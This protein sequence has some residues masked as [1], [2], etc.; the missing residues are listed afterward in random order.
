M[1][2]IP[3]YLQPALSPVAQPEAIVRAGV[4]RFTLLA[5]G[6]LRL[7]YDPH[8]QFVD[9]ASQVFWYRDQPVPD[10][11]VSENGVWLTLTTEVLRLR[12]RKDTPFSADTLQITLLADGTEWHYG[13]TDDANLK[14]TTR[15]LDGLSGATPLEPGLLSRHGW[16]VVDD[17][18][19]LLFN[20]DGW[21]EPRPDR[22][23]LDLYFF[24]YPDPAGSGAD[25]Q[26]ALDYYLRI[27]GRVPMLPRW[28]L[29][30]W[31]SRY[32][33]YSQEELTN[34]MRAFLRYKIPLAVC[35]VDM[36]W[37][38]TDTGNTS[39]GWTG[40]TWNRD[41]FPDPDGFIHWL[42]EQ[43][44]R[45][46]LNLHPAE[47]IHPHEAAY[48]EMA[49]HV[50]IDPST[51]EPVAFDLADPHFARGYFQYL[52]HPLEEQ[53][54]D[55]WWLDWQQGTLSSLPGLDPLWWLNH[56]HFYDRSRDGRRGFIFSRW[57]GLGN[58]RYPIGFSGDTFTDWPSL[59]FQPYLTATAANVAFGWWSHDIGG[60]M[61]GIE[62]PELYTRWVQVGIFSPIMRLH[63][64]NNPYHER[65][66]WGY[67][68]N[69]L[70]ATR[71][72]LQLRHALIPYLYT[73]AW[74]NNTRNR[75]LARPLYHD[76][77]HEEEAY[78]C[79]DAYSF[80]TELVA[81][82][83][84]TPAD[85]D[86]RL[87]R[88][89]LWLPPGDWFAFE[90]G[91]RFRGGRWHAL[92]GD[93]NH[94]PLFARAGAIVPLGPRIGWGGVD[95][96]TAFDIYL[97]PGADNEFVLYEDDAS[98]EAYEKDHYALTTY[99]LEWQPG[100][101]TFVQEP[102]GQD[103]RLVPAERA[104]TLHF[105]GIG[106]PTAISVEVGGVSHPVDYIF[107]AA[108]ATVT[109]S[110]LTISP[111]DRLT[112]RLAGESLIPAADFRRKAVQRLVEQFY[113]PTTAKSAIVRQLD[114]V[115]AD[116]ARLLPYATVLRP[117]HWRA[118]L[119]TI[120]GAGMHTIEHLDSPP[121]LLLW[122]NDERDDVRYRLA[123][124]ERGM[125]SA[126]GSYSGE[127]GVAPRFRWLTPSELFP[128]SDWEATILYGDL[129]QVHAGA[130][131][132]ED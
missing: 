32:W 24:A 76:Y 46:A 27:A 126:E 34:L 118:L 132:P 42:H 41:L 30:N 63:S 65:R 88:Q 114:D 12:Y 130:T 99:R 44:L 29:G 47:G 57:G 73:M 31:W 48:P 1:T 37:H 72:A 64:T 61:Q 119:E 107:D 100:E 19:S 15:T 81:A 6:L 128:Q 87:S 74:R 111:P 91:H 38:I 56:L 4:A 110:P 13:A 36:D 78:H 39:S 35:I 125:W 10:F 18:Y 84:I 77:P 20:G 51:E 94:V 49:R 105:R 45:T 40:Y 103:A 109:L 116:P 98:H 23:A 82:P 95:N 11:A 121:K 68:A 66:P 124:R 120:T 127:R 16:T 9:Q 2:V 102:V 106:E 7:E 92:Y 33:A 104:I 17:S 97:F 113:L 3:A 71:A 50:G 93:L 67:D 96:P 79:P 108:R 5:S 83:Y 25:Y 101:I 117:A 62:D 58:H 129:H 70:E 123:A 52:H 75:S 69:T 21:L 90:D 122:N 26:L 14:G 54:V 55:F 59:A 112:V 8:G 53:G 60:H 85:P 89:V 115:L 43:G 22:D 80:G 28:A 86:T 131:L